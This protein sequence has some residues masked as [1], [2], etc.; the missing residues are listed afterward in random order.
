[1]VEYSVVGKSIPRV[2]A[3]E[4]VTGKAIYVGDF[5]LPGM[6]HGKVVR[7]SYPHAKILNIN[8]SKAEKLPGVKA[9]VT[10]RDFGNFNG[11]APGGEPAQNDGLAFCA[12]A[13]LSRLRSPDK[14]L[15]HFNLAVNPVPVRTNHR[16]P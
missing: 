3:I 12:S 8:T 1:M 2:D 15:V 7:S 10:G 4:K 16:R 14:R 5:V 9:V 6:L 11:V 13:S